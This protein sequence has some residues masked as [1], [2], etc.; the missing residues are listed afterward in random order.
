M[1]S[2]FVMY[3]PGHA[4]HM[5]ARLFGLSPEAI[6]LVDKQLL[7]KVSLS[8]IDKE[9]MYQFTN[10]KRRFK[11]WQ[12]FHRSYA[13]HKDSADIRIANAID[14]HLYSCVIYPIHP[15]EFHHD[16][17][18]IDD[19]ECYYVDLDLDRWGSWVDQQQQELGFVCRDNES[20]YFNKYKTLYNMKS[21][22]LTAMLESP[23]AFKEEYHR[24]VNN[25]N[26]TPVFDQAVKLFDGW[27]LVR[28]PQ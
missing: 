26:I 6:P 22:N 2:I 24:V 27:R 4:G 3:M 7:N 15:Y 17:Q 21:I 16:F 28:V 19:T 20:E 8:T 12:D 11:S 5:L 13:D 9:S 1:K 18:D 10:V 14:G 25:M 23:D